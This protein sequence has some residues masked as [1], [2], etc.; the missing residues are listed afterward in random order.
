VTDPLTGR[1]RSI[2]ADSPADLERVVRQYREAR[3][4]ARQGSPRAVVER[5]MPGRY[6]PDRVRVRDLWAAYA[7]SLDDTQRGPAEA[8]VRNNL[9][10]VI[11]YRGGRIRLL[12]LCAFEVTEEVLG[13]WSVAAKKDGGRDGNGRAPCTIRTAYGKLSSCFRH[14]RVNRPWGDWRPFRGRPV[15]LCGERPVIPSFDS[16]RAFVGAALA[17]DGADQARGRYCDRGARALFMLAVGLRNAE[18]AALGWDDFTDLDAEGDVVV[19]VRHQAPAGWH[20]RRE[21]RGWGR[22]QRHPKGKQSTDTTRRQILEPFLVEVLRRLR[23]HQRERGYWRQDGP[24]FGVVK[25]GTFTWRRCGYAIDPPQARRWA[26]LAGLPRADEWVTHCLRHSMISML[27]A[28]GATPREVQERGGHRDL[29]TTLGYYKRMGAGLPRPRLEGLV[30][31]AML[32]PVI[33]SRGVPSLRAAESVG[34]GT[35][36]GRM[37][38]KR[39]AKDPSQL[40]P[41]PRDPLPGSVPP[42]PE[43]FR[44]LAIWWR[45]HG[46]FLRMLRRGLER[47]KSVTRAARLAAARAYQRAKRSGEPDPKASQRRAYRAVLARWER[48]LRAALKGESTDRGL[49]C[50][51]PSSHY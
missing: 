25:G 15:L 20:R 36:G 39:P 4:L 44:E 5:L 7:A 26:T 27:F 50:L 22:P 42:E 47:P 8:Y 18:A 46:Q 37:P 24:V 32:G 12:D 34:A 19:H 6:D 35:D 33:E 38:P 11:D 48:A 43:G 16:A 29:S 14:A 30:T 10:L 17:D 31:P 1:R 2:T 40:G 45:R 28:V 51:V 21:S 49:D 13:A 23:D 41:W 9:D 3:T